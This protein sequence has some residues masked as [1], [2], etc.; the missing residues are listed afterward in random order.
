MFSKETEL[1]KINRN[2][3]FIKTNNNNLNPDTKTDLGNQSK[4]FIFVPNLTGT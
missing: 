2:R 1:E 4:V 3:N